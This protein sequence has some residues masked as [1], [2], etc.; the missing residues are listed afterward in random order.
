MMVP[1]NRMLGLVA[2]VFIP[3]LTLMG[4]GGATLRYGAVGLLVAIGLLLIDAVL[5][6]DRMRNLSV[7]ASSPVHGIVGRDFEVQLQVSWPQSGQLSLTLEMDCPDAVLP[8]KFPSRVDVT[9]D[10]AVTGAAENASKTTRAA[11]AKAPLAHD[12]P[13]VMRITGQSR[14]IE[15]GRHELGPIHAQTP[16][17]LGFWLIRRELGTRICVHGYP[18]LHPDRRQLAAQLFAKNSGAIASVLT[19]RGRSFDRLRDYVSGDELDDIHWRATAKRRKPITKLYELE[20]DQRVYVAIDQSRLS[21]RASPRQTPAEDEPVSLLERYINTALVLGSVAQAQGDQF[22][23]L[24]FSDSVTG[25]LPAGTGPAHYRACREAVLE[26]RS[27]RVNA[28]YKELFSF[29]ASK[30]RRRSMLFVLTT[31]DDPALC[32]ELIESSKI[33]AD[34]HLVITAAV[35][36]AHAKSLAEAEPI[37]DEGEIIERLAAHLIWKRLRQTARKLGQNG[38]KYLSLE[39]DTM[40]PSLVGNYTRL[41]R[42]QVL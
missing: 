38:V 15:R 39:H 9:D 17:V 6:F 26:F 18:D 21:S 42:G 29:F 12:V 35:T 41:K 8:V 32:E 19:G 10:S 22:G 5:S 13:K 25:F 4:A 30:V 11:G 1:S 2:L 34:R 23:L 24:G 37:D 36:P 40:V 14:V 3:A 27:R 7:E 28:D 16:S 20:K 33:I 31:V